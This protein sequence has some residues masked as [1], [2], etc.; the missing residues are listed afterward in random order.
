MPEPIMLKGAEAAK[1]LRRELKA[2]FAQHAERVGEI[3]MRIVQMGDDPAAA[4]YTRSIVRTFKR[5][6][7]EAI[8]VE[9]P[10]AIPAPDLE[11]E[12][13]SLNQD[14][15]VH[16][17]V[18]PTPYP[19]QIPEDLVSGTLSPA[20][21]VDCI[22]PTRLGALF[23][24]SSTFAPATAAAVMRLLD[25]YQIPIEGKSAVVLGRSNTVG[26]PLAMLLL[27][28]HA[29]V[30]LL[31]SRTE[32]LE[33]ETRRAEILAVAMGRP[34]FVGYKH[35]GSRVVVVD[36]GTNYVGDE[37]IGDVDYDSVMPS[38]AAITPVPGGVGPL[39]NTIL[40]SN[41]AQLLREAGAG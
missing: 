30:T 20:K 17:V 23:A 39:T 31:H 5:V 36:V 3:G 12:L 2:E 8:V 26:K 33:A 9:L 38:T 22:T 40:A 27:Q 16:G 35:V 13:T 6:G 41:L 25:H 1:A 15:A 10:V 37:L 29:T 34:N 28:R 21:D 11:D 18:V 32:D 14:T 24:G 7:L 4:G 19:A